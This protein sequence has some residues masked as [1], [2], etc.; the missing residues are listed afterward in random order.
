MKP[1]FEPKAFKAYN[2]SPGEQIELDKFPKGT[3]RQG[4]QQTL[5]IA[6]GFPFL[7]CQKERRK[8]A[9]CKTTDT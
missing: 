3:P 4:I 2:L 1:G 7:L 8:T 9:T 5:P 6:Y